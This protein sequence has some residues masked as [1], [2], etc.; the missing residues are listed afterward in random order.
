MTSP[1]IP[2]VL[3]F[4]GAHPNG[5]YGWQIAAHLEA[6]LSSM[7]QTLAL[8]AERRQIVVVMQ[9]ASRANSTWRLANQDETATPPIFR[10]REILHAFQDAARKNLNVRLLEVA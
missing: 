8:M 3:E 5:A 9:V 10:A 4:L 6:P 7:G 2:R 1:N